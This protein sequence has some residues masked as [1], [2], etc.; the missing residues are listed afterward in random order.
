MH[1]YECCNRGWKQE[2]AFLITEQTDKNNQKNG[3][4]KQQHRKTTTT[5]TTLKNNKLNY[6]PTKRCRSKEVK[7]E[8][9]LTLPFDKGSVVT[10]TH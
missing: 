2:R 1:E 3:Y 9:S 7:T 8:T 6:I 4:Q 10:S 5:A